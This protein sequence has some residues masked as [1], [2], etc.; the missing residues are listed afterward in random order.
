MAEHGTDT[1]YRYGCRC[2]SCKE[3][4]Y[5]AT[6]IRKQ[7]MYTGTA[8]TCIDATEARERLQKLQAEGMTGREIR[9]FGL[10]ERTYWRILLGQT[11]RIRKSTYAKIMAIKGRRMHPRQL[12]NATASRKLI[13]WWREHGATYAKISEVTGVPESTLESIG[14][15]RRVSVRADTAQKLRQHVDEMRGVCMSHEEHQHS[16]ASYSD[17][18]IE[19][20]RTMHRRGTSIAEL[21]LMYGLGEKTVRRALGGGK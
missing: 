7:R 10:E 8:D 16:I 9:N 11:K 19:E 18:E 17:W 15:G 3:A 5:H 21:A 6:K 12:V 4:H 2:A 20:M 1:M 13:Q 14:S